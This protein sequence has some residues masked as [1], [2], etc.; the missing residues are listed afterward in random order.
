MRTLVTG[1]NGLIGAHLLRAL[2]AEGADVTALVRPSA[3][4]SHIADLP[5]AFVV[6]DVLEPLSLSEAMAGQDVVFHTAVAFSYWGHEPAAMKRTAIEGSR[7]VL[8]AAAAAGVGRVV[9][10]SSSV[11]LGASAKP[12]V[13]DEDCSA[14]DD[15]DEPAYV[16]AKIDQEREALRAALQLG[17][18]VVFACP[19]MSVGPFGASLGPSNGVITSYLADPLRLT[20]AGGCNIVSARDVAWGHLLLARHGESGRRYVLGS[21]NL[22]WADIHRLVAEL[23]GVPPPAQTASAVACCAIAVGEEA[24]ARLTGKPPLAT[25]AQARMV[26]RYYWY[27]HARAAAL[28]YAPRPAREALADALAWL[29]PGPYVSREAR[30]G[31]RLAREVYEARQASATHERRLLSPGAPLLEV[32]A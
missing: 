5:V 14:E 13:R 29:S 4:T 20:W 21:E 12:D 28:G 32:L 24:R 9:V 15:P 1:A 25:R 11:V 30:V 7:N 2:L 6:G 18:E 3:D 19:T 22:A 23:A 26:G 8:A 16:L 31:M 27:S 10:T 17:I